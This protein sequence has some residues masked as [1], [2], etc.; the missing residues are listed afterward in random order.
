MKFSEVQNMNLSAENNLG[1]LKNSTEHAQVLFIIS[2]QPHGCDEI[3]N[4]ERVTM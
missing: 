2:A 4:C 3:I 1:V